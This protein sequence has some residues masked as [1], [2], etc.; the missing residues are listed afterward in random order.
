M[1]RLLLAGLLLIVG[2]CSVDRMADSVERGVPGTDGGPGTGSADGA[3]E[4][5]AFDAAADAT[6]DGSLEGGTDAAT[7]GA[8]D[9]ADACMPR[10]WYADADGDGYGDPDV[11]ATACA[12]PS[13][14]VDNADDCNDDLTTGAEVNP[15]A[16]EVC[17][18]LDDDCDGTTDGSDAAD[19]TVY[20]A[21]CDGDGYAP[22][23][24]ERRR[25]C[26]EPVAVPGDCPLGDWVTREPADAASTDCDDTDPNRHP[27]AT[28]ACN[29]RDDNCDGLVDD[30]A[31]FAGLDEA[32]RCYGSNFASHY[33]EVRHWEATGAA[34]LFCRGTSHDW[35]GA[36]SDCTRN[37]S[38][39]DLV[40]IESAE[41]QMWLQEQIDGLR[42]DRGRSNGW[43]DDWWIGAQDNLS[44]DWVPSGHKEDQH[45]FWMATRVE[46]CE[47]PDEEDG[48]T[49]VGGAYVNW[50]GSDPDRSGDCAVMS[51][52]NMGRTR[53]AWYDRDCG[54]GYDFICESPPARP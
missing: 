47:N 6:V 48:C 46:F 52:G 10:T 51:R 54:D 18:G 53:G 21:D 38:N 50:G 9:A 15:G 23:D 4:A 20:Y 40:A 13:G 36:R 25:T 8:M 16:T 30:E 27:G 33:C 31:E 29:G 42:D 49:A 28:A 24:A 22:T 44:D 35:E 1:R 26:S 2:A 39:Y 37:G 45:W 14:F 19:A 43:Q 3:A 5:G 12:Q 34:Y 11:T 41:E 7:D 17:N 32:D